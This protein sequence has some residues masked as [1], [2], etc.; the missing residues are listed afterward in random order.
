MSGADDVRIQ[1]LEQMAEEIREAVQN[2]ERLHSRISELRVQLDCPELRD[3]P[4]EA[5]LQD[6]LLS[7]RRCV[8][9]P[10]TP[11]GIRPADQVVAESAAMQVA[12]GVAARLA[13][14]PDCVIIQGETGTGKELLARTI[15]QRSI[16]AE[17]PF[18]WL[19]GALM[20][21][22]QAAAQL[23]SSFAE[24][25]AGTLFIDGL[26]DL[27]DGAQEVLAGQLRGRGENCD[28][29]LL[30][31][32][33]VDLEK[34]VR[35][36]QYSAELWALMRGGL[37]LLPP[38]RERPEDLDALAVYHLELLCRKYR[39][40]GKDLSREY[41]Q[42]LHCYPWPGNVRELVNTLEQ[43]LISSGAKATLFAR[44]LPTHL[45]LYAMRSSAA[46]KQGL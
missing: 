5:A 40:P 14:S 6:N 25:G 33:A 19:P 2:L 9:E 7:I 21:A 38:L 45:R 17:E 35:Q 39:L 1:G 31:A 3:V 11:S 15:H 30:G 23:R 37:I 32:T 44:D 26:E 28:W 16:R 10:G 42:M 43:S 24:V 20:S 29:R 34:Q 27:E 22:D 13:D 12:L 36:G 4:L 46:G 41:L 18:I 8:R